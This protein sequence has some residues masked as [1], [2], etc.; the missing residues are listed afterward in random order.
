MDHLAE[1]S[2]VCAHNY[3]LRFEPLE[4]QRVRE[5]DLAAC[6]ESSRRCRVGGAHGLHIHGPFLPVYT[7]DGDMIR[8]RHPLG[9]HRRWQ[10]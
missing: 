6:A 7:L 2:K 4:P 10:G 5:L 3:F 1:K 8:T 9:P